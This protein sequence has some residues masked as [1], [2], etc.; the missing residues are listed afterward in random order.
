MAVVQDLR[1]YAA[2]DEVKLRDLLAD[3]R[4]SKVLVLC[5][6]A[7]LTLGGV[8]YGLLR[9]PE[10]QVTTVLTPVTEDTGSGSGGGLASVA[11]QFGGLASLAGVGLQNN[12]QRQEDVAVLKSELVTQQYIQNND[13]MPILFAKYWDP[14]DRRWKVANPAKAPTLWKAYKLFNQNVRQVTDD[15]KTGMI[16]LTVTWKDP[17]LAAQWANGLVALTNSYLRAKAIDESQRN[18]AFLSEQLKKATVVDIQQAIASL[19]EREFNRE[20]LAEG[21]QEYAL[22]VIDPAYT[23]EKPSSWGPMTLGMLGFIGGWLLSLFVV[24]GRRVMRE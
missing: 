22:K 6:V 10:Y 2:A 16:V 14:V 11:S 12:A 15:A 3:L 13:L 18:I 8:A 7:V 24:F 17:K 9:T 5:A 19:L 21:R 1:T 4:S 20:M 23:P